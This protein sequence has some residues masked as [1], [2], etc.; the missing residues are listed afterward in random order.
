M[1]NLKNKITVNKFMT[2]LEDKLRDN[3]DM[4]DWTLDGLI[5]NFYDE[6]LDDFV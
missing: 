6:A 5:M 3:S 2:Y 1:S 4:Y